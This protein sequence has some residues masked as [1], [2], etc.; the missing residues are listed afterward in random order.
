MQLSA[1]DFRG[2][3][4][5]LGEEA[6]GKD[7]GERQEDTPTTVH[8]DIDIAGFCVHTYLYVYIHIHTCVYTYIHTYI[9]TYV[10]TYIMT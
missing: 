10:H 5:G 4:T 6:R 3:V 7:G 1:V 9:P 2:K 8:V